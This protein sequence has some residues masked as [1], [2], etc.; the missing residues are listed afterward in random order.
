[1]PEK[2]KA[3]PGCGSDESTGWSE[4]AYMG[5]LNL[6]DE[7]FNYEE[8][9]EREFGKK[10]TLP[11]GITFFWWVVATVLLGVFLWVWFR[12]LL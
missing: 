12:W 8:F 4:T 9:S 1:M 7:D 2:A 11:H 10:K 6:P 5:G 3:C